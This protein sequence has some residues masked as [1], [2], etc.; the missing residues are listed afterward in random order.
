[1]H[2]AE[3][4]EGFERLSFQVQRDNSFKTCSNTQ[5][6]PQ[7]ILHD[8]L[9]PCQVGKFHRKL[10]ID[11]FPRINSPRLVVRNPGVPKRVCLD[12]SNE[13]SSLQ[14]SSHLKR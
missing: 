7:R 2:S 14:S 3:G 8:S 11:S 6:S 12:K 10:G 5:T 4:H 9:L 1:M 13:S